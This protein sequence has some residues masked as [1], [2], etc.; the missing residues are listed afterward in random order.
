M[1]SEDS[2]RRSGRPFAEGIVLAATGAAMAFLTWRRWPDLLVDFGQQLY[3]P[4]RLSQGERLGRD[5]F[6]LHGPLSQ[7]WHALLFSLFGVSFS[8][9]IGANLL[10]VAT[11]TFVLHRI[12]LRLADRTAAFLAALAFLTL[13][14][15]AQYVQVGNYNFMAPYTHEAAHGT[16]LA[17]AMVLF[18]LRWLE[19][20]RRRDAGVAGLLLGLTLLTKAEVAIAALA[21]ALAAVAA[22]SLRPTPRRPWRG[23]MVLL[24]G[25][26]LP[27]ALFFL[28]FSTYL[29]R[30]RAWRAAA[31][32]FVSLGGDLTRF[33]L[34]RHALGIDDPAGNLLAAVLAGAWGAGFLAAAWGIDRLGVRL[35]PFVAGLCV[36]IVLVVADGVIPWIE[37]PRL[38]PFAA[39]AATLVA[40]V[41]LL[42]GGRRAAGFL[43]MGV[44][45]VAMTGK[46]ALNLHLFHYGFFLALPAT[47]LLIAVLVH[48]APRLLAP[49]GGGAVFRAVA[50]AAVVACCLHHVRWTREIDGL[51]TLA[52]GEGGDRIITFGPEWSDQGPPMQEVLDWIRGSTSAGS[53]L[54]VLPEGIM[55]DYLARRVTTVPLVNFTT[56]EVIVWGETTLL[57]ALQRRPPDYVALVARRTEDLGLGRFGAAPGYGRRVVQWVEARYETA[58]RFGA[59]PLAGEGF[60]V[61]ILRRRDAARAETPVP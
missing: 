1:P 10:V 60:G 55:L 40:T 53:S 7:H 39:A 49:R 43:V 51:K 50:I 34:Y 11:L 8:T 17:C 54:V 61:R 52:I 30:G 21:A 33:A 47:V 12:T 26:V 4:W 16:L 56:G 48:H 57:E 58:A 38:L 29:D 44:F 42:M 19:E 37:L 14:A 32:G 6:Y 22:A 28:F 46:A 24:G 9:L 2:A 31:A 5:I 41:R 18:L 45:A 23:A 15:F 36:F 59:E 13:F 3:I 20:G 27:G 25:A 35:R